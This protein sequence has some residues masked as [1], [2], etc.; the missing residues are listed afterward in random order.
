MP[1]KLSLFVLRLFLLIFNKRWKLGRF[2]HLCVLVLSLASFANTERTYMGAWIKSMYLHIDFII[3]IY[4]PS[5]P[6]GAL[7]FSSSLTK[8]NWPWWW[9]YLHK[10]KITYWDEMSTHPNILLTEEGELWV[11][12]N[13]SQIGIQYFNRIRNFAK[14]I[15]IPTVTRYGAED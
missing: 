4:P 1:R 15:L 2:V 14:E 13:L 9:T 10:V 6:G 7:I 5:Y 12:P 3:I 11:L 8:D